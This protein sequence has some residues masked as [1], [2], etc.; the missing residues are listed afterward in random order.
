[1]SRRSMNAAAEWLSIRTGFDFVWAGII[2]A[3]HMVIIKRFQIGDVFTWVR[4]D[5]RT[6]L[7]ALAA[8]T[9]ITLSGLAAISLAVYQSA[10]GHR[11]RAILILHGRE[12]RRN[13]RGLLVMAVVS[14]GLIFLAILLDMVG[15]RLK[16]RF[17]VEYAIALAVV[18]FG[19]LVWV[20]DRIVAVDDKDLMNAVQMA[21]VS[22]SS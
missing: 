12:L 8:V 16:V 17:I 11:S 9:V 18:R 5:R 21:P 19:R 3:I 7:Y 1:M 13:W 15:D 10:A 4:L 22:R 6:D 20:F 2:L 14:S